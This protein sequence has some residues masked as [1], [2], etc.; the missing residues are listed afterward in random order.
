MKTK[1]SRWY[2]YYGANATENIT[3][4]RT[5]AGPGST[6]VNGRLR[7]IRCLHIGPGEL[8]VS[9]AVANRHDLP[10]VVLDAVPP[11]V[12]FFRYLDVGLRFA[13]DVAR[14]LAMGYLTLLEVVVE[15]ES[16]WRDQVVFEQPI[17]R[18]PRRYVQVAVKVEQE[19]GTHLLQRGRLQRGKAFVKIS[20]DESCRLVF[21]EPANHRRTRWAQRTLCR[22]HAAATGQSPHTT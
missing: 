3:L 6:G 18:L 13:T 7:P 21:D 12:V 4:L 22:G 1:A 8:H 2:L 17:V 9:C 16:A 5:L 10:H 20:M 15:D 11:D 14:E 19:R